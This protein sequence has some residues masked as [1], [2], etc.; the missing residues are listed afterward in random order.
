MHR[1][2]PRFNTPVS[3][4]LFALLGLA[5]SAGPNSDT[6]R[7]E[8]TSL[9]GQNRLR[10]HVPLEDEEGTEERDGDESSETDDEESAAEA[11]LYPDLAAFW[12]DLTPAER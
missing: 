5:C 9:D 12:D 4:S 11:P 6:T 7:F 3:I 8:D 10:Q 1:K 2:N